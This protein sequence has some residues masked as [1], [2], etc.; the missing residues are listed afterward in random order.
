[1]F[2]WLFVIKI[3]VSITNFKQFF[4][5]FE[6]I[7]ADNIKRLNKI[8]S[9]ELVTTQKNL[10]LEQRK[11]EPKFQSSSNHYQIVND[12]EDSQVKYS[13]QPKVRNIANQIYI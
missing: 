6:L 5:L 2:T 12:Q 9:E 13:S 10:A 7:Q 3:K 11:S 8:L 1:M 4:H